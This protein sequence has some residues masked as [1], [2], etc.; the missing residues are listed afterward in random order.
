MESSRKLGVCGAAENT[1]ST[2]QLQLQQPAEAGHPG[3]TGMFQR[4]LHCHCTPVFWNSAYAS[5]KQVN[6]FAAM[7]VGILRLPNK[8]LLVAAWVIEL[9]CDAMLLTYFI[10][11]FVKL[12]DIGCTAH[13]AY[14]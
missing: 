6:E 13:T 8:T 1:W 9:A 4:S 5:Q 10:S 12:P 14:R 3:L 2:P 7:A 11:P